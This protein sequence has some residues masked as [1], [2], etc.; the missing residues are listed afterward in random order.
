MI[1]TINNIK[2]PED[3]IKGIDNLNITIAK[4]ENGFVKK[5]F[6]SELSFFGRAY[7]YLYRKFIFDTITNKEIKGGWYHTVGVEIYDECCTDAEGKPVKI[8]QGI[9]QGNN[10]EWCEGECK[11]T[12]QVIELTNDGRAYNI[13]NNTIIW[14]E[15][16]G[17]KFWENYK[18]PKI[19]YCNFINPIFL[20]FFVIIGAWIIA[21]IIGF[22]QNILELV[23]KIQNL[24]CDIAHPFD[25]DKRKECKTRGEIGISKLAT[26]K[27]AIIDN[28]KPCGR[29]HPSPMLWQYIHNVCQIAGLNFSSSILYNPGSPYYYATYFYAPISKGS[30][31]V[32]DASFG[33]FIQDNAPAMT[34]IQ[35]L[36]HI[37]ELFHAEYTIIDGTLYFERSDNAIF[38]NNKQ[39]IDCNKLNTEGRINSLC[40][41]WKENIIYSGARYS[42]SEDGMDTEGNEAM[43]KRYRSISDWSND[44]QNGAV[45]KQFL[46]KTFMFAPV[47]CVGDNISVGMQNA[48]DF[49]IEFGF[50]KG[51]PYVVIERDLTS[52]PKIIIWNG[53]EIGMVRRDPVDAHEFW[54][55]VTEDSHSLPSLTHF[56]YN[57]QM[58]I[59][60]DYDEALHDELSELFPVGE[61]ATHNLYGNFHF[62]DRPK[63]NKLY[64]F[65]FKLN[66]KYICAEL[67]DL[68]QSDGFMRYITLYKGGVLTKGIIDEVVINFK[69]KTMEVTGRAL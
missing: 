22:C 42:Y 36:D 50:A 37:K 59:S 27:Q 41:T 52:I 40:W 17:K 16:G 26:R 1:I 25:A 24:S 55:Q 44:V 60:Q 58:W 51:N 61:L 47:R 28:S 43:Y 14:A 9:I 54:Q 31:R 65:D 4:K 19:Y 13:L 29:Y 64:R 5:S 57:Y 6:S 18:I 2:F 39:W 30:K 62:I 46:D 8:Y 7:E 11:I 23:D 63:E 68:I 67:Y 32:N 3:S 12:A 69:T 66:F 33:Q 34:C 48:F 49:P 21:T 10:I 15:R 20:Q 35:F 38:N 53:D 56:V 45:E